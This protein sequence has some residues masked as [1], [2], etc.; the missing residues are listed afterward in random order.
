MEAIY[1]G[2]YVYKFGSYIL[3]ARIGTWKER[4]LAW[5]VRPDLQPVKP[6]WQA[7]WPLAALVRQIEI[8][9]HPLLVP[10]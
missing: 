1:K 2:L 10:I 9:I 8:L 7:G 3:H 5:Q 6:A 4:G